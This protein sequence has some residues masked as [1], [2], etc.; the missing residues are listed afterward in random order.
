MRAHI[1]NGKFQSDKYPTTPSGFVPLKTTDKMAQDLLWKYAK[2]RRSIDAEFSE[3][4]K[5][6]LK[7]DGFVPKMRKSEYI[8]DLTARINFLLRTF[9]H[10]DADKFT[11]PDGDEWDISA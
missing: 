2:R 1:I 3:D 7:A 4:L 8:Q 10:E 9:C 6:A 5:F 11:F